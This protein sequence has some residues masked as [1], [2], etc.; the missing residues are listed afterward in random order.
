MPA[1]HRTQAEAKARR[2]KAAE[3]TLSNYYEN[4]LRL[5]YAMEAL[6]S[7]GYQPRAARRMLSRVTALKA[8]STGWLRILRR[9]ANGAAILFALL[10]STSVWAHGGGTDL[11]GCHTDSK[12][13]RCIA[14]AAIARRPLPGRTAI[15]KASRTRWRM[16]SPRGV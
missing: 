10:V 9:R 3:V 4:L 14:T 5:E 1:P 8:P 2:M 12:A 11:R 6:E 15:A 7:I 16:N 13:V